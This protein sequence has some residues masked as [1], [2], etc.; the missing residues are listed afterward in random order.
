MLDKIKGDFRANKVSV[1]S[2]FIVLFFRLSNYFACHQLRIIRFIGL[3]IRALYK[4][5]IEFIM[6]VEIP[7]RLSVGDKL[8]ILHGIG[9]VIN[10]N[11]VIGNDVTI[12]HN[13]TIGSK[14]DGGSC[15]VIESGVVIGANVVI[16]GN[17]T[18]GK[19]SIIGAG[20]IVTKSFP[21]NSIIVGNP[22]KILSKRNNL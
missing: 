7:D 20:S 14:C 17:I 9:L 3:P 13:T 11:V 21:A 5:I 18:I 10:Q 16:L 4:L 6:S 1:K 2:L 19:N 8:R 12:G 15:P 22:A